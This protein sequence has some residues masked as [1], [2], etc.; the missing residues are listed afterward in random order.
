MW[1]VRRTMEPWDSRTIERSSGT[2]RPPDRV[3][4]EALTGLAS[5]D[6]STTE[7]TIP[8]PDFGTL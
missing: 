6:E 2:G 1:G 8:T 4:N 7:Q 5:F 3:G